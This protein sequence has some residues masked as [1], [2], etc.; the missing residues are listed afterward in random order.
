MCI[1]VYQVLQENCNILSK[2]LETSVELEARYIQCV[3]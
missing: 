3:Q 1:L 2:A